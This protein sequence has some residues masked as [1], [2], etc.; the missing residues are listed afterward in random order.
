[1]KITFENNGHVTC[2]QNARKLNANFRSEI[3]VTNLVNECPTP[4]DLAKNGQFFCLIVRQK[5]YILI[6]NQSIGHLVPE[7]N[8]TIL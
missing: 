1:M 7:I 3:P 8:I 2:I 5:C 4:P 6:Q